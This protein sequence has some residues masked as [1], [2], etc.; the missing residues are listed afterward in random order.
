[1]LKWYEKALEKSNVKVHLKTEIKNLGNMLQSL[2]A[3]LQDVKLI[4]SWH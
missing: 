4:M 2:V 3:V 1:M